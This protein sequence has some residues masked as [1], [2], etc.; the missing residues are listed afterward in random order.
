MIIIIIIRLN[1][2]NVDALP[3][4][5]SESRHRGFMAAAHYKLP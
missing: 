3:S 2:G 4:P 1:K 5:L